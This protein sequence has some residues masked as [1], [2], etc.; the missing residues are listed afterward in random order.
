MTSLRTRFSKIWSNKD[1]D[2]H[3]VDIGNHAARLKAALDKPTTDPGYASTINP[4]NRSPRKSRHSFAS[5]RSS[6]ETRRPS[7]DSSTRSDD[8]RNESKP[9]LHKVASVTFK[10]FSDSLRSKAQLFYTAQTPQELNTEDEPRI[11]F[12]KLS[13]HTTNV[14][15]PSKSR[16]NQPS[17]KDED[18]DQLTGMQKLSESPYEIDVSIPRYTLIS[19]NSSVEDLPQSPFPQIHE[20]GA[21]YDLDKLRSKLASNPEREPSY[22]DRHVADPSVEET[23]SKGRGSR[24]GSGASNTDIPSVGEGN[25]LADDEEVNNSPTSHQPRRSLDG[26]SPF[27]KG[28]SGPRKPVDS[29]F[30]L[31]LR[32]KELEEANFRSGTLDPRLPEEVTDPSVEP[33]ITT[34]KPKHQNSKFGADPDITVLPTLQNEE[35]ATRRSNGRLHSK[36]YESDTE[37]PSEPPSMGSRHAWA[38]TRVDRERRYQAI[39]AFDADTESDSDSRSELRLRPCKNTESLG[40]AIS[41]EHPQTKSPSDSLSP[42]SQTIR[43]DSPA[44]SSSAYRK[45]LSE[46]SR[47]PSPPRGSMHFAV[48]AI[49]RSNGVS[50]FDTDQSRNLVDFEYAIEAIERPRGTFIE[51][52][53]SDASP[54]TTDVE[55]SINVPRQNVQYHGISR[56]SFE[57]TRTTENSIGLPQIERQSIEKQAKGSKIKG[58]PYLL[59]NIEQDNGNQGLTFSPFESPKTQF[60]RHL[61]QTSDGYSLGPALALGFEPSRSASPQS[62]STSDSCAVTTYNPVCYVP[63][64]YP[65]LHM[66]GSPVRRTSSINTAL[67]EVLRV[68]ENQKTPCEDTLMS[69]SSWSNRTKR[70]SPI[71]A[72]SKGFDDLRP[73]LVDLSQRQSSLESISKAQLGEDSVSIPDSTTP[74]NLSFS[75]RDKSAIEGNESIHTPFGQAISQRPVEEISNTEVKATE[76]SQPKYDPVLEAKP[77]RSGS[78]N[79]DGR[80]TQSLMSSYEDDDLDRKFIAARLPHFTSIEVGQLSSPNP[81]LPSLAEL[82]MQRRPVQDVDKREERSYYDYPSCFDATKEV[83][84]FPLPAQK[85][86][87][88]DNMSDSDIEKEFQTS[89]TKKGVWWGR[90][91][92]FLVLS[93]SPTTSKSK[94]AASQKSEQA[95][96]A[97]S[98]THADRADRTMAGMFGKIVPRTQVSFPNASEEDEIHGKGSKKSTA[99]PPPDGDDEVQALAEPVNRTTIDGDIAKLDKTKLDTILESVGEDIVEVHWS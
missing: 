5:K 32:G 11:S 28:R 48:E 7:L 25:D 22:S 40:K 36:S 71:Q 98:E 14:L 12:S 29:P 53:R 33:N 92:T 54:P 58:I 34:R 8:D 90:N 57:D 69:A 76:L 87:L 61:R 13:Q 85:R 50:I 91:E 44:T 86:R 43:P 15:T 17:K 70:S 66:R 30:R 80:R 51:T 20:N 62:A 52:F 74:T 1:G 73:L 27:F 18:L 82:A 88:E 6:V 55:A 2:P 9:S 63:P 65:S 64:P 99:Y 19:R 77:F 59:E 21:C 56:S 26:P 39:H 37:S 97:K 24:S 72:R 83:L 95:E 79:V 81:I 75:A 94:S 96:I 68:K 47:T 67:E 93:N 60:S 78:E 89:S 4:I 45:D 42:C 16:R 84:E 38:Q 10:M 41:A 46:K 3:E 31:A 35:T 23:L 49:D